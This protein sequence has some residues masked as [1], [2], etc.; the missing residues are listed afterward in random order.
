MP[1]FSVLALKIAFLVLL[2]LFI[3]LVA[4]VVRTDVAGRPRARGAAPAAPPRQQR[5]ARGGTPRVVPAGGA[6]PGAA[7]QGV[8]MRRP[9]AGVAPPFVPPVAVPPAVVPPMAVPPQPAAGSRRPAAAQPV[10][11]P[12][13]GAPGPAA[14][15]PASAPRPRVRQDPW[16]LAIDTGRRAGERLELVEQVRIGRS[17][18]CE[19]EL[20]DDFVSGRHAVLEH[21]DD[22]WVLTDLGSTNGTFVNGHRIGEPTLVTAADRITIGRVQLRVEY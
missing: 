2:W 16:V 14:R 6:V 20:D 10:P 17:D 1:E 4:N 9:A 8:A 19:L 21:T 5:S 15:A 11:Q 18:Q 22:G 3:G 13:Q 7:G 12:Q